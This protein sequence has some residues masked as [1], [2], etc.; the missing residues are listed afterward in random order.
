MT[1]TTDPPS[2]KGSTGGR[3]AERVAAGVNS[4][5]RGAEDPRTIAVSVLNTA[6]VP[7]GGRI[8]LHPRLVD[9]AATYE[10]VD[11]RGRRLPHAWIGDAGYPPRTLTLDPAGLA[12]LPTALARMLERLQPGLDVLEVSLATGGKTLNLEVSVGT[13]DAVEAADLDEAARRAVTLAARAAC[14]RASITLHRAVPMRVAVSLPPLPACSYC[15]LL[16][17]PRAATGKRKAGRAAM[18]ELFEPQAVEYAADFPASPAG[19]LQTYLRP[20]AEGMLPA[21]GP[22]L[23][24][25]PSCIA[26][27]SFAEAA[28]GCAALV[29]LRNRAHQS[30][31]ARIGWILPAR[32]VEVL[33][34]PDP[35][36][37]LSPAGGSPTGLEA[38]VPAGGCL[39][40]RLIWD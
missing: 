6:C 34:A 32:S 29:R 8:D 37:G 23:T 1:G 14:T 11:E 27:E 15:T 24:V 38:L 31:M 40:L 13:G 39:A 5:I 36:P 22:L 25:D 7:L 30:R 2:R 4:A 21:A 20:C 12:D 3:L 26:L 18:A 19:E 16:L 35:F 28:D 17:R 9:E 10:I 33:E